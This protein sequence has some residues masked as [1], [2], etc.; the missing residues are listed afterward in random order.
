MNSLLFDANNEYVTCRKCHSINALS[1]LTVATWFYP[2]TID[3]NYRAIISKFDGASESAGWSID[4]TD[5]WD[6]SNP[7]T[8]FVTRVGSSPWQQA[9]GPDNMLTLN[10]WNFV[11]V[12]FP[13]AGTV[14]SIYHGTL[15]SLVNNIVE[16]DTNGG[17][18]IADDSAFSLYLGASEG[19]TSDRFRG[20]IAFVAIWNGEITL[21][22]LQF[23]QFKPW[24]ANYVGDCRYLSF[25]GLDFG[26]YVFDYSGNRNDGENFGCNIGGHFLPIN[27]NKT[28]LSN[29]RSILNAERRFRVISAPVTVG[30]VVNAAG[31]ADITTSSL[32]GFRRNRPGA[33]QAD[34]DTLS[35]AGILREHV[36][37]AQADIVISSFA[38]FRR[39]R[40]AAGQSDIVTSST[41]GLWRNRPIA[42]DIVIGTSSTAGLWRD[43]P[44]AGESAVLIST[45]AG[46]RQSLGCTANIVTSSMAGFRRNRVAACESS[47]LTQSYAGMRRLDIPGAGT[48]N[49]VTATYAGMTG[50][51]AVSLEEI[52]R[53]RRFRDS[54][55]FARRRMKGAF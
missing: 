49:I 31:Q 50:G 16:Q 42:G 51:L 6:S 53:N 4:V 21:S 47:I 22:G 30:G 11:G 46:M 34:I 38:G 44:M 5:K 1:T 36:A 41:A 12:Y 10:A 24:L 9:F 39:E 26:N 20:S 29:K 52:F 37:A 13:L 14:P 45:T 17:T 32:A 48:A 55:V 28:H 23:I 15:K 18:N 2:T 43:R 33:A 8:V 54:G 7:N 40:V 35:Y 19:A 25:P 27:F 3:T